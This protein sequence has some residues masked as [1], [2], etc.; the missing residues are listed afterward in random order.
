MPATY[1][2]HIKKAIDFMARSEN[3]WAAYA[4]L[5]AENLDKRATALA[6]IDAC[7]YYEC[8]DK[9][10]TSAMQAIGLTGKE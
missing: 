3:S 6:M 5:K 8:S 9:Y 10:F 4:T 1:Y 2:A 7:Y